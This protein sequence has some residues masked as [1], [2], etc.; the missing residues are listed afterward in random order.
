MAR[1]PD[2]PLGIAD[3]SVM[4]TDFD[5]GQATLLVGQTGEHGFF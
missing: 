2:V 1:Y 4:A 3:A 5:I